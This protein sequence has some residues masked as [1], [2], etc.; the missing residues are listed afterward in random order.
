MIVKTFILNKPQF[1]FRALLRCRTSP[2]LLVPLA[3]LVLSSL[4][5][6][7]YELDRRVAAHFF[8]PDS[9]WPHGEDGWVQ[10]FY[11]FGT[12]PALFV[13]VAAL[14]VLALGPFSS[15]FRRY[16]RPALFLTLLLALGPGLIVN[17][18]FKQHFG[19]PRPCQ[20]LE[21]GGERSF[22]PTLIPDFEG[23]GHSFPSGHAS[24]GFYWIGLFVYWRKI[25]RWKAL[26]CLA[27][28]LAHGSVMGM[29]RML[30]GAHWLSDVFWS[31]GFIYLT[32]WLI[33]RFHWFRAQAGCP[34]TGNARRLSGYAVD[35]P[36]AGPGPVCALKT[37]KP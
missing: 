21:F 30:Q 23:K 12:F 2:E 34:M 6:N 18:V 10:L 13:G 31:A 32:A 26:L 9:G 27:A 15:F 7:I 3:V 11:H 28:G 33:C 16:S 24:M 36:A 1:S 22:L 20:I 19:R 25:S 37:L 4:I 35:S 17:G 14:L 8:A 29:G 5:I